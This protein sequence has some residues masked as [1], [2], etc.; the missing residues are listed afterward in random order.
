MENKKAPKG[1][2]E[3]EEKIKFDKAIEKAKELVLAL[4]ELSVPCGDVKV[5]VNQQGYW[6][7][8]FIP[9]EKD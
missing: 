2:L 9:V 1:E 4:Q 7:S 6:F 5:T 8:T 3:V